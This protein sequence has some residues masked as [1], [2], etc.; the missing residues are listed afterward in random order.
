[1]TRGTG[2]FF[3]CLLGPASRQPLFETSACDFLKAVSPNAREGG[4]GRAHPL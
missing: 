1:M 4:L 2:T 3:G